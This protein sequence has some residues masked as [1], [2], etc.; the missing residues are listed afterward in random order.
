M[1]R[2]HIKSLNHQLKLQVLLIISM[3]NTL[4]P[5]VHVSMLKLSITTGLC[6]TSA[7]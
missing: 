6:T 3:F 2:E 1:P 4:M 5:R 7:T